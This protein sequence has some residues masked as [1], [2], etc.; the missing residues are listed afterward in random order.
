MKKERKKKENLM[1]IRK[2]EMV[3]NPGKEN[4]RVFSKTYMYFF[5]FI[6]TNISY[7]T[8]QI[9]IVNRRFY[10]PIILGRPII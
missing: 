7:W 9:G 6:S 5:L 8:R 2:K 4:G 1:F 3:D 10:S